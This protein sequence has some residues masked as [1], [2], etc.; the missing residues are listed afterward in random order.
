MRYL[1][2]SKLILSVS[3]AVLLAACANTGNE[4][5]AQRY[6]CEMGIEF[7]ARFS[8]ESVSL[9]TTRG[10]EMLFRDAKPLP[11]PPKPYEYRNPRMSAEFQLGKDGNEALLRYPLLPLA[12]RCV[13]DR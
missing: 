8:G 2:N 4:P 13:K 1:L 6:R 7:S 5:P 10:Y 11:D 3:A 9:D 12:V